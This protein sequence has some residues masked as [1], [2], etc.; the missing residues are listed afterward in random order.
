M[1][2][3]FVQPPQWEWYIL[4]YFFLGG[5]TGGTYALATMLRLWGGSRATASR[6]S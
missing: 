4:W 1:A 6:R 5:L 2:E 3:H